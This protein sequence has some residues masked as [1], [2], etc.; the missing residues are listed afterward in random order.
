[1]TFWDSFDS[2]PRESAEKEIKK[3]RAELATVREL[4][5][6]LYEYGTDPFQLDDD[7]IDRIDAALAKGDGDE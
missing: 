7:F 4:L 6:N 1:M 3:L 2:A 5:R